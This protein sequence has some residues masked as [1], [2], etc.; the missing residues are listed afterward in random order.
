M[1]QTSGARIEVD[2]SKARLDDCLI[3]I[4]ATESSSDLKSIVVE[5]VLLLQEKINDEDDTP[6]YPTLM[7]MTKVRQ[8]RDFSS[9][10]VRLRSGRGTMHS[11]C[12]ELTASSYTDLCRYNIIASCRSLVNSLQHIHCVGLLCYEVSVHVD[13][14]G[15]H[16]KLPSWTCLSAIMLGAMFVISFVALFAFAAWLAFRFLSNCFTAWKASKILYL[17][18]YNLKEGKYVSK[19]QVLLTFSDVDY[20]QTA[21]WT[22]F[23]LAP[24]SILGSL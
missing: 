17:L 20:L 10:I 12:H 1:R 4:T 14:Y 11:H 7:T 21:A 9:P 13:G 16:V 2:V 6:A 3:T 15:Y 23:H 24:S 22:Y 18:V 5:A 19:N 8:R